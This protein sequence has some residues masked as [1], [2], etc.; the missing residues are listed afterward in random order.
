MISMGL[1]PTVSKPYLGYD[2]E[3]MILKLWDW[4]YMETG[5][6]TNTD[7]SNVWNVCK[8]IMVEDNW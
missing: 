3:T 1:A 2:F 4:N 7:L 6:I 8:I 5:V